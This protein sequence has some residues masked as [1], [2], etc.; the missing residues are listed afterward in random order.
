MIKGGNVSNVEIDG[1]DAI[2]VQA[3]SPTESV[4]LSHTKKS[5]GANRVKEEICMSYGIRHL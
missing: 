2:L 5:V 3:N 1:H 4:K